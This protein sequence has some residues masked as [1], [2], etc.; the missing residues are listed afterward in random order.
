MGG[1]VLSFAGGRSHIE[2]PMDG[3]ERIRR[4]EALLARGEAHMKSEGGGLVTDGEV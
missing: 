4:V 1:G 3:A 2:Q